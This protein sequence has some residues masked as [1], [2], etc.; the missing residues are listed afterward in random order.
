[1]ALS[2][3]VITGSKHGETFRLNGFYKVLVPPSFVAL[4]VPFC[5]GY[6]SV[7]NILLTYAL[8]ICSRVS[9]FTLYLTCLVFIEVSVYIPVGFNF[10]KLNS[11]YISSAI[12]TNRGEASEF[13]TGLG[14]A[15][16]GLMLTSISM[17]LIHAASSGVMSCKSRVR[18]LVFF[19]LSSCR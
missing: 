10:G 7:G 11:A 13:L 16:I 14:A 1:M 18:C 17:L 2:S 8:L 12:Q 9:K 3:E 6:G 19:Y 5:T 4:I 15:P